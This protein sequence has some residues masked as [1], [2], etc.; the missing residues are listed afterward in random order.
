MGAE[1]SDFPIACQTIT[2]GNEQSTFFPRVFD[3]VK[4]AGYT[5]VEIGFRH[6]CSHPPSEIKQLLDD[7]GLLLAALHIGG[8]LFDPAQAHQERTALDLALEYLDAMGSKLLM[9]SGLRFQDE[10][11]FARDFMTLNTAAEECHSRGVHLLYHNHNWEF[12][13][14]AQ[15]MEALIEKGSRKLGFCPDIGWVMKG[16][17]KVTTFLSQ[18]R[19]RIGAIHFKD[20]ATDGPGC[21]TV[22]LGTGVAP[23]I[24]AAEWVQKNTNGMWVIAEQDTADVPPGEAAVR[25]AEFLHRL[26]HID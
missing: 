10:Q 23:L 3:E 8:N 7:R 24:E 15:V 17:W 1:M 5:G 6:V 12:E 16:G 26:L 25:N 4:A 2:W 11:Q 20:F 13:G 19:D 22:I 21:D 14:S 9:Y 18:I